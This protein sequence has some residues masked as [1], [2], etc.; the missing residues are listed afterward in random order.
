MI[1]YEN[2]RDKILEN[3]SD[4]SGGTLKGNMDSTVRVSCIKR[5]RDYF[6]DVAQMYDRPDLYKPKGSTLDAL[7]RLSETF[8]TD[9]I[10]VRDGWSVAGCETCDY[11]S[12]YG[13]VL[14]ITAPTKSVD[15][16]DALCKPAPKK[17]KKRS[18]S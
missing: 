9:V 8:G 13:T 12:S 11:G 5:G 4:Y 18:R 1:T 6:V 3:F 10:D 16:L 14:V 17:S 2:A 7:V 15:V